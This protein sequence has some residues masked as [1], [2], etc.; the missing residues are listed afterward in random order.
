MLT[1]IESV[2]GP[3]WIGA[4]LAVIYFGT[5]VWAFL[6]YRKASNQAERLVYSSIIVVASLV[7]VSNIVGWLHPQI[8]ALL[9]HPVDTV[10]GYLFG[11]LVVVALI[12]DA[13]SQNR[14]AVR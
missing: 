14:R 1:S 11:A 3:V 2:T 4:G 7:L 5:A 13:F 8:A 10:L 6:S 9:N 12:L